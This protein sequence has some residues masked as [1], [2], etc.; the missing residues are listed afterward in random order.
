MVS[1]MCPRSNARWARSSAVR[2]SRISGV[3]AGAT[4]ATLSAFEN[5]LSRP[6]CLQRG[7][8]DHDDYSEN[9]CCDHVSASDLDGPAKG[10]GHELGLG[11]AEGAPVAQVEPLD[12]H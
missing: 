11:V 1:R 9:D 3:G 7:K 2:R 4:P 10:W 5:T 8:G 6:D 12:L